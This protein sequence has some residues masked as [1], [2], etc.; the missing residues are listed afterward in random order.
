MSDLQ[1]RV[2]IVTGGGKGLGRAFALHL[3]AHGAA[4]VVNNR[5]REVDDAGLGPADHVVAE[6]EAAGGTALADHSPVEDPHTPE[7]LVAT[8]LE[9]FGRLD[10]L[11][12]SAGISGA[13][14]FHKTTA[15][16]FRT[17]MDINVIGTALIAAEATRV[18]REAGHGRVVLVS[19]TAGLHGEPTLSAYAASKG[20]VIALGRTI[21]MEGARKDVLTNVLLPYATTPMTAQGMDPRHANAMRS[22]LVAPV[23][24]ALADPES[25]INGQVIIA[26]GS[27]IRLGDAVEGATVALPHRALRP[28]ALQQLLKQ[29]R[30]GAAQR[31]S[32]AQD[33]FQQFAADEAAL[34]RAE[35][36]DSHV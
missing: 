1:G 9:R 30:S 10:I 17:V 23:V 11:V 4:V 29:S 16:N 31:Y 8:C 24:T 26:G 18:M 25:T 35:P 15:D 32:D 19:S 2:A 22:E 33:A 21:A 34:H 36:E 14:M 12:T 3:A 28:D 20:A 27:G 13:Q 6:I 7:R 5:N